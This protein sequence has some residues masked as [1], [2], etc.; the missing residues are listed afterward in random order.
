MK[1]EKITLNPNFELRV[2]W[3][4][5]LDSTLSNSEKK[6]ISANESKIIDKLVKPL[7]VRRKRNKLDRSIQT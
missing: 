4:K 2:R 3:Q 7:K 5:D 1:M 6:V